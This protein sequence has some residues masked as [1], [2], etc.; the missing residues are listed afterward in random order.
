MPTLILKKVIGLDFS[1][2]DI[3]FG[4]CIQDRVFLAPGA[5]LIYYSNIITDTEQ[6]LLN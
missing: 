6:R 3:F 4:V 2:Y 1:T 5:R